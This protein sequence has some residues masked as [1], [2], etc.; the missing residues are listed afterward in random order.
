MQKHR[1]GTD[2][3]VLSDHAEVPGIGFLPVNTFVLHAE[4]PP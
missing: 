4:Q 3:T 1:I 2:V